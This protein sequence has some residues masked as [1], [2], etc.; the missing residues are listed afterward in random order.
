MASS[1]DFHKTFKHEL[2]NNYKS[3]FK[4]KKR[5]VESDNAL[6]THVASVNPPANYLVEDC[7]DLDHPRCNGVNQDGTFDTTGVVELI[8]APELLY[9]AHQFKFDLV[10]TESNQDISSLERSSLWSALQPQRPWEA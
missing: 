8:E 10:E 2:H 1:V 6:D 4:F 7:Q 5:Q 3:K 9:L